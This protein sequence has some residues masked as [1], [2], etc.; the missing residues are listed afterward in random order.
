MGDKVKILAFGDVNGNFDKL[1]NTVERLN[2]RAGPFSA[3]LC[4]GRFFH[5]DGSGNDELLPYLQG[6][7]KV[8]EGE[9]LN[10][11]PHRAVTCADE[12]PAAGHLCVKKLES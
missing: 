12:S 1:F 9:N 8:A 3:C 7:L 2:E 10:L 5:P 6:R 4:S 11:V